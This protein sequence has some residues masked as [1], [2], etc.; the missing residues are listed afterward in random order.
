MDVHLVINRM[1]GAS[2]WSDVNRIACYFVVGVYS[3]VVSFWWVLRMFL[4][5]VKNVHGIACW[6]QVG[7][8]DNSGLLAGFWWEFGGRGGVLREG[9]GR[10]IPGPLQHW[11]RYS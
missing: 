1:P 9:S 6:F 8:W 2:W 7:I 4:V 11:Q 5:G 10:L 3:I